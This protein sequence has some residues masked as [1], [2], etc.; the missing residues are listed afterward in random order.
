MTSATFGDTVIRH[1][2]SAEQKENCPGCGTDFVHDRRTAAPTWGST[3]MFTVSLIGV[4]RDP[5]RALPILLLPR[6]SGSRVCAGCSEVL[7]RCPISTCGT[8]T[9]VDPLGFSPQTSCRGCGKPY[10]PV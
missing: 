2:R 1:D 5:L 8:W 7:E 6:A 9:I 4:L 3:V 10:L